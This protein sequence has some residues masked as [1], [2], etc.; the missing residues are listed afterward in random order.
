[1]VSWIFVVPVLYGASEGRSRCWQGTESNTESRG[2]TV[3][4]QSFIPFS[5]N[6]QE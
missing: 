6:Q 5:N 1:M 2:D 4:I 3:G